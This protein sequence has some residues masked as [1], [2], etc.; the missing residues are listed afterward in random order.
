MEVIDLF[1]S[2]RRYPSG[3]VHRLETCHVERW[4]L[5][6]ECPTPQAPEHDVEIT[7]LLADLGLRLTKFRPRNRHSRPSP[8]TLRSGGRR[9]RRQEGDRRRS[10]GG[11]VRRTPSQ[12]ASRGPQGN[13]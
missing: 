12:W 8:S 10:T 4:G 11:T 6:V 3:H 2:Q 5:A 13:H 7:W 9:A 1:S